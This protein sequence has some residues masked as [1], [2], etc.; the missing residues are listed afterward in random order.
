VWK[1]VILLLAG[2]LIVTMLAANIRRDPARQVETIAVTRGEIFSSLSLTATVINDHTV[3][4]TALLDGEIIAINA[5]EGVQVEAGQI[6]A[7]LDSRQAKAMLDKAVAELDYERQNLAAAKRSHERNLNISSNGNVSRQALED[8]QLRLR[9]AQAA[10][11]VA[12]AS[13]TVSELHVQ[14]ASI[15]APFAG[16][17]V[18]QTAE[19]GQW[20]EAG[21]QLFTLVASDGRVVEAQVDAGDASRVSLHQVVTLSSDAWPGVTWQSAVDWIA[22]TITQNNDAGANA[23]AVRMAVGDGAPELLLG[24]QLDVELQ[25][26]RRDDVLTLPLQAI[27]E[28]AADVHSVM[29][30]EAGTV[31]RK[32][33]EVGLMTIDEAEVLDGLNENDRVILPG[34]APLEEGDRVVASE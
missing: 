24:Q 2:L 14:N 12:I 3:T 25:T 16:T 11:K 4:L 20:V 18:E 6:L 29:V 9:S 26:A 27:H 31:Q 32:S 10:V 34:G 8:S 7:E 13:I 22:P 5:R 23:F 1:K 21:T 30:I 17:I 33:F 19:T 28:T 15:R